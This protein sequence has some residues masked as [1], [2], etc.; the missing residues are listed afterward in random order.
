VKPVNTRDNQMA[1][2]K[3]K[4]ISYRNQCHLATSESS[5]P[6]TASPEYPKTPKKQDSDLKFYLMK[7]IEYLKDDINNSLKEI[8]KNTFKQVK[9]MYEKKFKFLKNE[10]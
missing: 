10:I 1:R 2:G 4:N 3:C 8:Q 7:T 6:N 5:S 9:D